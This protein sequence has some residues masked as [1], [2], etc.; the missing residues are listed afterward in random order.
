MLPLPV[1]VCVVQ[2]EKGWIL[3]NNGSKKWKHTA[4]V[5]QGGFRPVQSEMAIPEV[6]PGESVEVKV[7]Y[8]AVSP[9]QDIQI[10]E[11]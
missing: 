5:H 9:G 1:C 4:L 11:R 8:P 7:Q 10:I 3:R 2:F 6:R